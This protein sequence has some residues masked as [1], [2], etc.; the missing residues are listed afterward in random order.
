MLP[1]TVEQTFDCFFN[2]AS[3]HFMLWAETDDDPDFWMEDINIRQW[4]ETVDHLNA[5]FWG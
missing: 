4:G 3:P 2:D 5:D 1:L